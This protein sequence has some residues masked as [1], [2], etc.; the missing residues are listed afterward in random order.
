MSYKVIESR[1]GLDELFMALAKAY[2]H[3]AKKHAIELELIVIGGASILLNYD[4]R[5]AT[6]DVDAIM[7]NSDVLKNAIK[8]VADEYHLEPTWLNTDIE[9]TSSFSV[10]LSEHAQF[11]KSYLGLIEVRTIKDEYLIAMKLKALRDYKYDLSDVVGIL[12]ECQQ[13][14]VGMN[15]AK[16]ERAVMDLYGSLT[17][18][19]QE[20]WEHLDMVLDHQTLDF[21]YEATR[22]ME[23]TFYDVKLAASK[24][25]E[26]KLSDN[27][28]ELLRLLK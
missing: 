6:Y 12:Y 22:E 27:T 9:R 14:N 11:Y 26:A 19:T 28:S 7:L 3:I 8:Q 23:K 18:I 25:R 1:A 10:K 20:A 15:R 5:A 16:V 24:E 17:K 21:L 13:R 4:F 2:R